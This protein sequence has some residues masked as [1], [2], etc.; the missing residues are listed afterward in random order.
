MITASIDF[1]TT[2]SVV[3]INRDGKIEM[4]TLG[5]SSLETKTVLFYSFEDRE[6]YV[7]D[8][9]LDELKMETL[10]R[11]LVALKSF[12]GASENIETT[13]GTTTYLLSDLISIILR[14]FKR[15]LEKHAG[16]RI[17][18]VV[19]GR[20]V[21]FN[22][23]DTFL[24]QQAQNRL[25]SAVLQAGFKEVVF[26]YEPI[27]AALSYEKT[28]TKEELILVADIGGGTTDY[29][30]IRV[31][32]NQ[33]KIDRKEDIL[34]T[35]G[36]Y[37][38]GN[39]FDAEII[40]S[41]V[42][43]HLGKGSLYKNMGKEME[44]GPALYSDFSEWHKFQ[45]MYDVKVLNTIEKFIFM[46]YDKEKISRL[47]ELIKEGLYFSFSEKIIEAKMDLSFNDSTIIDM[48][49]FYKPFEEPL[50]REAFTAVISYHIEKIKATLD[51]TMQ[52]AN[53]GYSQIDRVFLTGG[54]TLVPAV[55]NIYKELFSEEKLV[56]T[57]VFSSVG[58]GLAIYA[59]EVWKEVSD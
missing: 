1:G 20:P 6:F 22:D 47:L 18:R 33:N 37:V 23:T 24:D 30:I 54:S 43:E 51:E 46:T 13:L 17:D 26:Q 25:E 21:H 11:Y 16:A 28:I 39:S 9:A 34:A 50:E 19:L 45:K 35:H 27:A 32:D 36:T 56:H 42:V 8:D 5:K 10:G 29:T 12:L 31:G 4:V 40:K 59:G 3:G 44:I 49:M 57:D 52:M 55:K 7:G 41:F 15:V 53:I 14:R 58:Y 2:N 48:D 38:G